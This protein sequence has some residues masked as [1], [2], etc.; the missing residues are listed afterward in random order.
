MYWFKRFMTPI[1]ISESGLIE[2][3]S[4]H[5]RIF[6]TY[7]V[8]LFIRFN[9]HT[10]TQVK[11]NEIMLIYDGKFITMCNGEFT[12]SMI[13]HDHHVRFHQGGIYIDW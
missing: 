11:D 12:L 1:H 8:S 5:Y 6:L 7:N 10:Y 2:T 4:W 3:P 9:A 13:I